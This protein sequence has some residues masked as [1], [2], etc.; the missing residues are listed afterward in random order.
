[1]SPTIVSRENLQVLEQLVRQAAQL[2]R[3]AGIVRA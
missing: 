1:M 3:G 2:P